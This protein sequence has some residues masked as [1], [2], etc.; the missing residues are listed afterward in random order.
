MCTCVD[1]PNEDMEFT[2]EQEKAIHLNA[3]AANAIL[4]A[5]SPEEFNK[6]DGL[7]EAMEIWDTLQLAYEGSPAV[8][9]SKIEL[10]EGRVGRFV[11]DDKETPQEMYDR[12]M[13][14]VNKIRGLGSEDMTDHFV[15]KRLLRVFVPRN[16]ILVSMIRERKDYKRLSLS[17]ILGRIV[18]NEMLEEEAC[19]LKQMVKNAAM[20]KNQ[21]IGLKANQEED[22]SGGEESE[23]EEMALIVNRFKHFLRK[24]GYGKGRKEDD[25]GK[26][27]SKRA[28]FKCGEYGHF[29]ADCPKTNEAKHKVVKKKPDHAHVAEAHMV[30]VW[31]SGDEGSP[32]AMEKGD[33]DGGVATV[34]IKSS[35]TKG[36]LFNILSDDD[37][38]SYHHACFMDH[39][40]KVMPIQKPSLDDD[41]TSD[42]DSDNELD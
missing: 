2:T 24:S 26:R 20:I 23:D 14:L 27:Q 7:E 33:G 6:V 39:G 35:S 38:D 21:E 31:Y 28:C 18:S 40:R 41:N 5:L 30:E 10:L 36:R 34:A 4:S 11:M 16:P 1:V 22:S 17:D 15:V 12:M 32:K 3:Q 19:E 8:R 42:E 29:I 13:L 37:N 9:E 25:K